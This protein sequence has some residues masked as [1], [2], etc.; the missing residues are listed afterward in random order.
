MNNQALREEV[1]PKL[2]ETQQDVQASMRSL[3]GDITG[4]KAEL[5]TRIAE[6]EV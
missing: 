6:V 3:Q 1:F 2:G 5:D 4:L